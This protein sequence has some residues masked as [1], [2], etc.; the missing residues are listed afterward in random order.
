VSRRVDLFDDRFVVLNATEG[1]LIADLLAMSAVVLAVGLT[2]QQRAVLRVTPELVDPQ[3]S[4][5]LAAL[6]AEQLTPPL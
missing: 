6:I 1:A 5:G 2:A 4:A 3:L